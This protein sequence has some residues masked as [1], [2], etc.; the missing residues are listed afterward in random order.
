MCAFVCLRLAV[1]KSALERLSSLF[2]CR[3]VR[4][5]GSMVLFLFLLFNSAM[6]VVLVVLCLISHH[7]LQL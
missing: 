3:L 4:K 5:S 7:S 2:T 6:I 1:R